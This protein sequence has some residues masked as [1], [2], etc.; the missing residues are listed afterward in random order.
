M[1][2]FVK[3]PLWQVTKAERNQPIKTWTIWQCHS[4]ENEC[5]QVKIDFGFILIGWETV[6]LEVSGT[7]IKRTPFVKQTLVNAPKRFPL[8]VCKFYLLKANAHSK[9]LTQ[10][11]LVISTV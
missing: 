7:H 9:Q 1:L 2:N 4:R 11:E 3:K 8:N 6:E 5:K 10:I